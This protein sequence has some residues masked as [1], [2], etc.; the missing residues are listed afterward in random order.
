MFTGPDGP[1]TADCAVHIMHY[2]R[3]LHT[4]LLKVGA[5]MPPITQQVKLAAPVETRID[6]QLLA[7]NESILSTAFTRRDLLM[8]PV[9]LSP[10][11]GTDLLRRRKAFLGTVELTTSD[12]PETFMRPAAL[13]LS[14]TGLD[15]ESWWVTSHGRWYCKVVEWRER[16]R[17]RYRGVKD[18]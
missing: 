6:H 5:N 1:M 4:W 16:D 13:G 9:S 8:V 12:D 3:F 17:D 10:R 14:L 11:S 7:K 18:K 15:S 2:L